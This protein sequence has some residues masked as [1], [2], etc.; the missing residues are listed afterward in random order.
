MML[1][2]PTII[3]SIICSNKNYEKYP[4]VIERPISYITFETTNGQI[5]ELQQFINNRL[6]VEKLECL[7]NKNAFI[8]LH[9]I[10]E[11]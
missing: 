9:W 8:K 2:F 7:H 1:E 11:Y 3:K 4:S 10:S 5:Q 6:S